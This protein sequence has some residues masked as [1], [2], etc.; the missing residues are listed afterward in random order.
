M[1]RILV[2]TIRTK[3]R[4]LFTSTPL[5]RSPQGNQCYVLRMLPVEILLPIAEELSTLDCNMLAQ[6]CSQFRNILHS[7]QL[8]ALP[9]T[10]A[11]EG[12]SEYLSRFSRDDPDAWACEKCHVLHSFHLKD[13]VGKKSFYVACSSRKQIWQEDVHSFWFWPRYRHV[14]LALKLHRQQHPNPRQQLYLESLMQRLQYISIPVSSRPSLRGTREVLPRIVQGRFLLKIVQYVEDVDWK[15]S[16]LFISGV[17]ETELRA[18]THQRHLHEDIWTSWSHNHRRDVQ[19]RRRRNP[20]QRA[21]LL[22]HE[23]METAVEG[24]FVRQGE[25]VEQSCPQCPTDFTLQIWQIRAVLCVWSDLG[26]ETSVNDEIWDIYKLDI[27]RLT[28]PYWNTKPIEHEPGSIR[29]LYEST[30]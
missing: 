26:G 8:C 16:K 29:R 30:T 22:P 27:P 20:E 6:T 14:Q 13:T 24:A 23:E 3:L 18:C 17:G 4:S 9:S 28:P 2:R 12:H 5:V 21:V 15:S 19:Y 7:A 10:W 11:H 1:S 25:A